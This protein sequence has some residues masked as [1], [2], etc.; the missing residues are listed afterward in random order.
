MLGSLT[1][2]SLAMQKNLWKA[3]EKSTVAAAMAHFGVSEADLKRVM[4]TALEKGG[5]YVDLYF[6]HTFN[7]GVSLMDGQVNNC[8]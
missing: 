1:M 5:D 4:S 3:D 8:N 7:N 6:E 2:P